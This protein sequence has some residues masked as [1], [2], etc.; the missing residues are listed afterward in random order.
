MS[1]K[2][3]TQKKDGLVRKRTEIL[4]TPKGWREGV[5]I[6][7]EGGVGQEKKTCDGEGV[8][9]QKRSR[10]GGREQRSGNRKD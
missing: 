6:R 10:S 5:F 1:T 8:N 9:E 3:K 4:G 2:R 7:K